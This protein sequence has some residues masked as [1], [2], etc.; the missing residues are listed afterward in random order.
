[1]DLLFPAP[2]GP[3]ESKF[4][5]HPSTAPTP[6]PTGPR[7]P[8]RPAAPT[9]VQTARPTPPRPIESSSPSVPNAFEQQQW[10]LQRQQQQHWDQQQAVFHAQQA[11]Q[12]KLWA[13]QDKLSDIHTGFTLNQT[14]LKTF[15]QQLSPEQK[16]A[17]Q[18]DTNRRYQAYMSLATQAGNAV[19][20]DE[21]GDIRQRLE[22]QALYQHY[23]PAREINRFGNQFWAVEGGYTPQKM[24]QVRGYFDQ[25]FEGQYSKSIPADK[26]GEILRSA[27]VQ[28]RQET[29]KMQVDHSSLLWKTYRNIQTSEKFPDLWNQFRDDLSKAERMSVHPTMVNPKDA[30]LGSNALNRPSQVPALD[31]PNHTGHS[32][33]QRFDPNKSQLNP[34]PA[35]NVPSHTGHTNAEKPAVTHVFEYTTDYRKNYEQ[36][37]GLIPAGNQV[38]HLAPRAVFNRSALA[39]EWSRRGITQ[40]DYPENL[41]ALPQTK[42]AYDKSSIKVQHSGSHPEWSF[43]A[44]GVLRE[45]QTRL[46]KRYGSLDKVPDD[47]MKQKK[48]DV[49]QQLREDLRDKDLGIDEGW[50]KPGK[51]GMDRLSQVQATDQVG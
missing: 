29:G 32:Q 14:A 43:H 45:E 1:M 12:T 24:Q 31:I 22:Q 2:A 30:N 20:P 47:V 13:Q 11:A 35:L 40:L 38:H 23:L 21:Q 26:R 48:N 18:Q 50:V 9:P 28:Y 4:I 19:K 3:D 27:D 46:I 15:V 10:D 25:V 8:T 34:T 16:R 49:M 44:E 6:T 33:Q 42:D 7:T 39:Q 41:Q 51:N 37:Y 36:F 17:L 5:R